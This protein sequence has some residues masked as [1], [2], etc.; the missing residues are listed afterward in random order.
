MVISQQRA[1][2]D[3]SL[4]GAFGILLELVANELE[5]AVEHHVP[6]VYRD[7][8]IRDDRKIDIPTS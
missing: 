6:V 4:T 5:V 7:Q 8:K 2:D 1:H 3:Q